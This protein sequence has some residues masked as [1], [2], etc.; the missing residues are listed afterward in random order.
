MSSHFLDVARPLA[1]QAAARLMELR[2][3][4]LLKERKADRSIVTNADREADE[5]IRG[6]LRRA[7]P[8]HAILT[9]ESG[10][11]GDCRAEYVWVVDPL[12]GTKAYVHGRAGFS[13]MIGLLKKGLPYAGVVADPWEGHVFEATRGEGAFHHL[14]GKCSH[15]EVSSRATL[16][17]MPVI[18]STGFPRELAEA[19]QNRIQA[20]PWLEPVNSVGI[21]VGLL[22]RQ[23]ADI[24]INHH[25]VHYWDTCA[26]QIILEEAGGLFTFLDGSPLIYDLAGS[27]LH[28]EPT[29]ATNGP[30]HDHLIRLLG[31]LMPQVQS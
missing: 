19:V 28:P 22:V 26:P 18:T 23:F 10:L 27:H 3:S 11:D 30:Q 20:G 24:Y 1:L 17:S 13:V 31:E 14:E 16:S 25:A 4:P 8:D 6:G 12:D 29:L 15:L 21:K 9:E 5:I 2:L 7:F